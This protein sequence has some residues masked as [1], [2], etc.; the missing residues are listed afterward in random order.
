MMAKIREKYD[1]RIL[2]KGA[3]ASG[4]REPTAGRGMSDFAAQNL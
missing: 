4:K 1:L 3:R 2:Q